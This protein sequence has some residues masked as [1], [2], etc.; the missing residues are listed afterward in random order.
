MITRMMAD[1]ADG[2]GQQRRLAMLSNQLCA[3]QSKSPLFSFGVIAD[4]QYCD[5]PLSKNYSGTETRDYRGSLDQLAAAVDHW[6]GTDISFVAQLGDLIDGQNNGKYGHGLDFAEP[7]SDEA[8]K[9]VA[10]HINR[11]NAPFYHALGNHEL[12]KKYQQLACSF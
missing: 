7:K 12:C 1:L 4:V 3:V 9:A 2:S 5:C 6:N 10:E 11:C 8:F